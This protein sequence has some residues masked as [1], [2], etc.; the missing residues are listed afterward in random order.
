MRKPFTK[1][2]KR[3]FFIYL[4]GYCDGIACGQPMGEVSVISTQVFR[5][6]RFFKRFHPE[7]LNHV[8]FEKDIQDW[9]KEFI[10]QHKI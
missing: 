5:R 3:E 2:I 1:E 7:L 8:R 9:L 4:S 6:S 10:Q